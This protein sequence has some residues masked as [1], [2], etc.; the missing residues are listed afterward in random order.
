[1]KK[2]FL[3]FLCLIVGFVYSASAR[4]GDLVAQAEMRYGKPT[5]THVHAEEQQQ[6]DTKKIGTPS[7]MTRWYSYNGLRITVEYNNGKSVKEIYS[8]PFDEGGLDKATVEAL[9]Q[10]NSND[11]KWTPSD[12]RLWKRED[13]ATASWARE[14]HQLT[15]TAPLSGF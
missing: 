9:L 13:G 1:V 11:K 6:S 3:L 2:T 12:E 4:L 15:I 10:A 14:Y 8:K 5:R 7:A